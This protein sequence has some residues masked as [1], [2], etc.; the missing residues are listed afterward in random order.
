MSPTPASEPAAIV[1]DPDFLT[2]DRGLPRAQ[3]AQRVVEQTLD[4]F[5]RIDT[6]VSMAGI[7]VSKPFSDFLPPKISPKK[8]SETFGR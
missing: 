6:L 1:D 7:F 4:R 2:I 3:T 8:R 5:G